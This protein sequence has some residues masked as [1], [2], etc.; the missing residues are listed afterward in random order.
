MDPDLFTQKETR[1]L[2]KFHRNSVTIKILKTTWDFYF[3]NT[4]WQLT[5]HELL[6]FKDVMTFNE[7]GRLHF[8]SIICKYSSSTAIAWYHWCLTRPTKK[9]KKT[10]RDLWGRW[11]TRDAVVTCQRLHKIMTHN[12]PWRL[13]SHSS[14]AK[15]RSLVIIKSDRRK[16]GRRLRSGGAPPALTNHM[17][18]VLLEDPLLGFTL[19]L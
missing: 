5:K 7:D 9:G 17:G 10:H 19:Y 13:A 15:I 3:S 2:Q 11:V 1:I 6:L 4:Q 16:Y 14:L 18:S 8:P 12:R